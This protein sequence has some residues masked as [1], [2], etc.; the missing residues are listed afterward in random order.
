MSQ[1][2]QTNMDGDQEPKLAYMEIKGC[3]LCNIR[4][5]IAEY[6]TVCRDCW[7]LRM[8]GRA[9]VKCPFYMYESPQTFKDGMAPIELCYSCAHRAGW[10]EDLGP[11]C[12][13]PMAV[14]IR[15]TWGVLT[16]LCPKA[17]AEA[18]DK[19]TMVDLDFC[20]ACE[21]HKGEIYIG[22]TDRYAYCGVPYERTIKESTTEYSSGAVS[23][24]N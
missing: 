24:E 15:D 11:I 19:A 4:K 21:F 7:E 12:N 17:S 5:P 20:K 22:G 13:H 2:D 6:D 14:L 8:V 16:V 10:N 18:G 3:S 1:I 9:L 23:T